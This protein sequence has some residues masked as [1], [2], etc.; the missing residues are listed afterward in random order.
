MSRSNSW[1]GDVLAVAIVCF[2]LMFVGGF[3]A[4]GTLYLW[5]P[6]EA[7]R[8]RARD[9]YERYPYKDKDKDSSPYYDDYDRV[10]KAKEYD[11]DYDETKTMEAYPE[12]GI[13]EI[14]DKPYDS[15]GDFKDF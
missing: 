4:V 3:A 11:Y 10:Y 14:D 2:L 13:P 5:G 1:G 15:T 7:E 6:S 8:K 9:S 12:E